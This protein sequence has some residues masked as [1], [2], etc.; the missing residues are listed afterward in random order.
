MRLLIRSLDRHLDVAA[1]VR[2]VYH[3]CF[4]IRECY[5]IYY[6]IQRNWSSFKTISV[7][8]Q[9]NIKTISFVQWHFHFR[10]ITLLNRS[11]FET[12][13][14]GIKNPKCFLGD[15]L[16]WTMTHSLLIEVFGRIAFSFTRGVTEQYITLMSLQWRPLDM[17][18]P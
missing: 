4:L 14:F 18:I 15:S 6:T 1:G 10:S 17:T 7:Q 11:L 12:C 8:Y 5:F 2:I 16:T 3:V 13:S 9:K